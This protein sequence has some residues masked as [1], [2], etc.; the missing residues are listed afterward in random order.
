[1][2]F[3]LGANAED[4]LFNIQTEGLPWEPVQKTVCLISKQKVYL[5]SQCRRRFVQYPNRRCTLGASAEDSL[6]IIQTEGLP[7]EPVQKTV[8]LLSKKK[9]YLGS[10]RRRQFVYY[11]N[12]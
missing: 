5:G 7:W 3:T 2:S 4:G 12:R 1:M 11:P 6:F 10:Q 9:V 8:C